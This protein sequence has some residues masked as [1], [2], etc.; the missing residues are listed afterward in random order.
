MHVCGVLGSDVNLH[1]CIDYNTFRTA[2]LFLYPRIDAIPFLKP[3]IELTSCLLSMICYCCC[4][5]R[6]SKLS[7]QVVRLVLVGG[8]DTGKTCLLRRFLGGYFDEAGQEDY[9]RQASTEIYRIPRCPGPQRRYCLSQRLLYQ[10]HTF[11]AEQ[12]YRVRGRSLPMRLLCV[13][14]YRTLGV[15]FGCKTV[16]LADR[17]VRLQMVSE[18]STAEV[19][20]RERESR[21]TIL[22][23]QV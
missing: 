17:R 15:D 1:T 12:E 11:D 21:E 9:T 7:N 18:Q 6:K 5:T 8:C 19:C 20:D 2:L 13:H 16:E 3:T 23:G 22:S 4:P 14:A 10:E